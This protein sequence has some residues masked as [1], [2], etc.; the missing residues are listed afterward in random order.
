MKLC[1]LYLLNNI[2]Y[3]FAIKVFILFYLFELPPR[4]Q[5]VRGTFSLEN[6][7]TSGTKCLRYKNR[8]TYIAHNGFSN[9]NLILTNLFVVKA[10]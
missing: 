9:N 5:L 8:K 3:H 4:Q 1:D 2:D 7:I 6:L 10:Q